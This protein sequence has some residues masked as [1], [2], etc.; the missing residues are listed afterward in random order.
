MKVANITPVFKKDD[1]TD[2]INYR[3]IS[4]LANLS[5]IFEK[6]IYNQLSIFFDKVLSKY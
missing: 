3:S 5:K 4:I 1:R 2:K 6:S